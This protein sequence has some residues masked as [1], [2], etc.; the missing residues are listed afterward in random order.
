[1][2]KSMNPDPII[3]AMSNPTPEIMPDLAKKA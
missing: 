1:M 2:V 3:F